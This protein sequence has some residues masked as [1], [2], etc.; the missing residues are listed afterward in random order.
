MPA[1]N[2]IV[3]LT[4]ALFANSIVELPVVSLL[5]N[6]A[7]TVLPV[8]STSNFLAGEEVP[9]PTLPSILTFATLLPPPPEV[10]DLNLK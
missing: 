7:P 2:P 10:L 1:L 8:K 5:V 9:I 6:L 3:L 4:P